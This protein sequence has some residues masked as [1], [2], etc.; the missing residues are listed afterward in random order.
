VKDHTTKAVNQHAKNRFGTPAQVTVISLTRTSDVAALQGQESPSLAVR[1]EELLSRS[2]ELTVPEQDELG[3]HVRKDIFDCVL[4]RL[5]PEDA[6]LWARIGDSGDGWPA[7]AKQRIYARI[8]AVIIER[9]G[10]FWKNAIYFDPVV[11]L[12]VCQWQRSGK[13]GLRKIA[14]LHA[15]IERGIGA[16]LGL[17]TAKLTDLE[18]EL[19]RAA[20]HFISELKRLFR[21]WKSVL[22]VQYKNKAPDY[23][24]VRDWHEKTV[25]E[26]PESFP[27]LSGNLGSGGSMFKYIES[28]EKT[29]GHIKASFR[30]GQLTPSS[31]FYGWC[32]YPRNMSAKYLQNSLSS[33]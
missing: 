29:A 14:E 7:E 33:K 24:T 23:E 12:R 15:A 4:A 26:S 13:H 17:K 5:L 8:D 9:A 31:F 6:V 18:P 30:L 11:R 32:A 10:G 20:P 3:S 19:K 28:A 1:C 2:Q 22:R 21:Q 27:C 16:G 25:R